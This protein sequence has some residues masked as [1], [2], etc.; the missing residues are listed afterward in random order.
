MKG[1]LQYCATENGTYKN[2]GTVVLR[3]NKSYQVKPITDNSRIGAKETIAYNV[4]VSIIALEL[5][6]GFSATPLWYFRIAFFDDLKMIKLGQRYYQV[7]YNGLIN[8]NEI[9]YHRIDIKFTID[10][11]EYD[12]FGFPVNLPESEGGVILEDDGIYIE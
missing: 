12:D 3:K 8:I 11:D 6:T 2:A 9:E 10:K 7:S 5:N 4:T 1:K